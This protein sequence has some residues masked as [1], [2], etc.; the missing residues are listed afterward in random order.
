MLPK[1]ILRR[2][3]FSA[4]PTYFNNAPGND[5]DWAI[6]TDY[7]HGG[8]Q[9]VHNAYNYHNE[10]ILHET[11]ILDL[12]STCIPILEFWH[13]AKTEGDVDECYVEVSTDG[14]ASYATISPTAY[15]GSGTY[16]Q[17]SSKYC[18]WEDSYA[19]WGTGWDSPDNATWWRKESFDLSTYSTSN[20]RF[21]FRLCYDS[22]YAQGRAGWFIDDIHIYDACP[23]PSELIETS[24]TS[25]SAALGWTENGSATSWEYICKI[26][27]TITT[28]PAT[29]TN[30]NPVTIT[31]LIPGQT[32]EWYV[33]ADCYAGG[34]TGQS[35][36]SGPAT[37]T[38]VCD[39]ASLPYI[40][41][42]DGVIAPAFP[43]CMTIEN[44]NGDEYEWGTDGDIHSSQ[45]NAAAIYGSYYAMDDWF[46]TQGLSLTGGTSYAVDFVY[47]GDVDYITEKLA[48]HWGT[49]ASSTAMSES[50]IFNDDNITSKEWLTGSTSFTPATTGT[51]YVGFYG[52]SDPASSGLHVDNIHI[53]DPCPAPSELTAT[54]ITLGSAEK[55]DLLKICLG[56]NT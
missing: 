9:C 34:G 53:Y 29:S 7:Y 45:P 13:I 35:T 6:N 47:R 21:R 48:V 28:G 51:Y 43:N 10:N 16:D 54:N 18:F 23:A 42:F 50:T 4:D 17:G 8:A 37:F 44:T 31:G 49:S 25:N 3:S 38:T 39:T 12:S 24:I 46:F 22:Y 2:S 30:S 19:A 33:W 36:W 27:G 1:Q 56:S 5:T 55:L 14:G 32:Y 15:R 26:P 20:V 41:N 52:Y 40:E 11:G